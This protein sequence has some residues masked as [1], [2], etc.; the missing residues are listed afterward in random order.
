MTSLESSENGTRAG[1]SHSRSSSDFVTSGKPS[2]PTRPSG[3]QK[4]KSIT[5]WSNT[6]PMRNVGRG[7]S[8]RFIQ[9]SR[10]CVFMDMEDLVPPERQ[11]LQD[12][13]QSLVEEFL[14][15]NAT[16]DLNKTEDSSESSSSRVTSTRDSMRIQ[17]S[18]KFVFMDMDNLVPDKKQE[19]LAK[20]IEK[21]MAEEI[22]NSMA[23]PM[24][25]ERKLTQEASIIRFSRKFVFRDMS[26]LQPA[27][28]QQGLED[29]V[30]SFIS[31]LPPTP[32]ASSSSSAF[33]T[34]VR[35]PST[36][37]G[38]HSGSRP[39]S[40]RIIQV[41]RKFVFMDMTDLVPSA[42]Q[43]DELEEAVRSFL[44]EEDRE[45]STAALLEN[46]EG[47]DDG[48][49]KLRKRKSIADGGCLLL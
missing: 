32:S 4:S 31:N 49:K 18:R 29:L 27:I 8:T 11:D 22:E 38:S 2:T 15:A 6:S 44:A 33:Q 37:S 35:N 21:F 39:S 10:Q 41:S 46:F 14:A 12:S 36:P 42:D 1:P 26:H 30:S 28:Q 45:T 17:I 20:M 40:T 16:E 24:T 34:E 7:E 25:P 3:L 19:D 43:Q 9:V 47:G 48:G 5:S 23:T 13:L